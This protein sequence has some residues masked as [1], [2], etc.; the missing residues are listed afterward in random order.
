M[1]V[2]CGH[3]ENNKYRGGTAGDQ[4]GTEY[5][6]RAW[7]KPSYGWDVVL[8]HPIASVG[9]M[10]AKI[11]Q[12]AAQNNKIG[13]DQNE[14][15][16]FYNQLKASNWYPEKITTGCEADCSSSTAACIIAAGNRLGIDLIK[17]ISPSLTTYN[18]KQ[19][20]VAAGYVAYT[21]SEYLT[22][23]KSLKKGDIILSEKHHVVICTT[24]G[25]G[26]ASGS[27]VTKDVTPYA[28]I[29]NVKTYLNVRKGPGVSYDKC[30]IHG[31]IVALP[32]G[33]CVSIDKEC[34]AWGHLANT[35]GA[36]Y[37]VNLNYIKR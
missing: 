28:G 20:L 36:E 27:W 1:V 30:N 6:E 14:R 11:A 15:L 31:T 32:A 35:V 3:D 23:E 7:Y 5:Y 19:A 12:A 21:N 8:R 33:I 2:S 22:G 10:V 24:D 13:Y 9:P 17:N 25:D 18:M 4:T 37:W 29:V 34:G 26:S 16:T